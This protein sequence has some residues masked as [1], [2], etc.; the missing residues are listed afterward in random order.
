MQKHWRPLVESFELL[1]VCHVVQQLN[2]TTG[3]QLS[4]LLFFFF[5]LLSACVQSEGQHDAVQALQHVIGR[6][7]LVFAGGLTGES[8]PQTA[9]VTMLFTCALSLLLFQIHSHQPALLCAHPDNFLLP[10]FFLALWCNTVSTVVEPP[11]RSG[12]RRGRWIKQFG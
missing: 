2:S 1:Q 10:S 5:F 12:A 11:G 9:Q 8:L 6:K 3:H 4:S 7:I